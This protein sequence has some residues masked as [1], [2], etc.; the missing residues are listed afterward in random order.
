MQGT[1]SS[2]SS[3]TLSR[4]EEQWIGRFTAM[5]CPCEVLIERAPEAVARRIVEAAAACAWRIEL[6]FSR[7]RSDGV[8]H[9]IN[10]SAG[11][12]VVLDEESAALIDFAET[13][14]RMSEGRFDITSGVLRAVWTF[15]GGSVVPSQE[16]IDAVMTCVGWQHVQWRKPVLQL[17]PGMQIDLGGIG[18]EYAVDL[19]AAQIEQIAPGSSC[20]IN[21]GGDVAVRNPRQDGQPWRVGIE[22][23]GQAGKAVR[24]VHLT[25]G[26][27]ATSGDSRRFVLHRGRRYSHI[28][29]A[30]TGWP[31]T[32]AP[33]SITVAADT[34]TQAGTLTTL[35]MLRGNE[36]EEFLRASGAKYWIQPL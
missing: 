35:A 33:H 22:A 11:R 9:T 12:A 3:I 27:L 8:V 24:L 32:D 30:R 25:R 5:A 34:C 20:L 17:R 10:S 19:A 18:K 14:T 4:D 31:V 6:K 15:D 26:G 16:E 1:T 7:Y 21:F 13:L 36:C 29:D 23:A 28:I 2:P